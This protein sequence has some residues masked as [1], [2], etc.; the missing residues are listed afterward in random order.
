MKRYFRHFSPCYDIDETYHIEELKDESDYVIRELKRLEEEKQKL[1]KYLSEIS[2]RASEVLQLE[3]YYFIEVI[4]QIINFENITIEIIG[5]WIWV[6][7]E[8]KPIK[9][10]LKSLKFHWNKTRQ[11]WQRK[12]S[13]EKFRTIN[14]KQSDSWIKDK[15]GCETVKGNRNFKPVLE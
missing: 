5:S 15:Y 12:P 4:N 1:E 10:T 2:N 9:E 6:S 14:S 13:D 11:L 8:T 7:G 3:Y